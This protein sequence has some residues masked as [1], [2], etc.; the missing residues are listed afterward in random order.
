MSFF[1]STLFDQLDLSPCPEVICL[2][3]KDFYASGFKDAVLLAI[4]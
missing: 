2:L 1:F 3:P 4:Y